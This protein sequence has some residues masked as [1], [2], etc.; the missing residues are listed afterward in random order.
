MALNVL[1]T[2][3][4]DKAAKKLSARDKLL[5]DVAVAQIAAQPAIGD[6]RKGDL[7]GAFVYKFKLNRQDVLLSCHLQPDKAAPV[8]VLLLSL[9]PHENFYSDL[10]R[11]LNRPQ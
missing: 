10:K 4:F 11:Q 1:A 2:P 3:T 9:G 7:A 5:L 8:S 6:E